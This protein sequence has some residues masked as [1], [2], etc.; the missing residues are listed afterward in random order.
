[1]SADSGTIFDFQGFSIYDGPGCRTSIFL[2]GC[3][4]RCQWCQNP[5]G[6]EIYPEPMLDTSKCLL[7]GECKKVCPTGAIEI[8]QK[9][10]SLA[11]DRRKCVVC[12]DQPCKEV[13]D[14]EAL[15]IAGYKITLDEVMRRVTRD[16][17]YW[18][19]GGGV[20][21]TGGEPLVQSEFARE[22][23]KRCNERFIHTAIE[24][25]GFVPW[26]N[27]EQSMPY[28]DWLFF[29]I[30]HLD[31]EVHKRVTGHDNTLVLE[32]IRKIASQF[33]N[34]LIIRMVVVPNVNDSDEYAK[35]FVEFVESLDRKQLEVNLL[36]L[37]HLAKEKYKML[38]R[39][40]FVKILDVP[41]RENLA[42]LKTIFDKNKVTCY[43]GEDTPF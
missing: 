8:E 41:S 35:M 37:H 27:I 7:E 15:R 39:E 25:E 16:R 33:K 21:L 40:Y 5:E 31:L 9:N 6:Q 12:K 17:K 28:L 29:D 26:E 14:T 20:T 34:R 3:M 24:T 10:K 19:Q 38:G 23:L 2:K 36:P 30:K 4:L 42:H 18:G 11:I 32:N 1:M 22:I 43:V 13:C